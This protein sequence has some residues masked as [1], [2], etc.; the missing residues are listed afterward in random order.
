[1]IHLYCGFFAVIKEWQFRKKNI[2]I[3]SNEKGRLEDTKMY[4]PYPMH[5]HQVGSFLRDRIIGGFF[6][7][8]VFYN[9][10]AMNLH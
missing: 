3:H 10:S 4:I 7:L 9:F 8:R 6:F 2:E 5:I 1:M